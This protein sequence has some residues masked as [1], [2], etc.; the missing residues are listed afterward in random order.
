M[1]SGFV[2]SGRVSQRIHPKGSADGLDLRITEAWDARRSGWDFSWLDGRVRSTEP[3]WDYRARAERAT[4]E[5]RHLLDIDTGGGEFLAALA[6]LPHD[7]HAVEAWQPNVAVA[8]ERL[9]PLGATVHEAFD[10]CPQGTFDLVLN[11][12]GR[13]DAETLAPLM[14]PGGILLTQQVG[15]RNHRELNEALALPAP[16]PSPA[17]DAGGFTAHDHRFLIEADKI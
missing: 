8:R 14:R 13:L 10:E 12:H 9:E 5:A 1:D 7:T 15:S 4:R 16:P 17:D 3:P 11:R 2:D 6:P